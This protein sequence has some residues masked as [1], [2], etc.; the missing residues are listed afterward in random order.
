MDTSSLTQKI[1]SQARKLITDYGFNHF[2]RSY[3]QRC[4]TRVGGFKCQ[5]TCRGGEDFFL[6][7]CE[8]YSACVALLVDLWRFVA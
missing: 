1:V 5:I 8:T 2:D 4:Q 3:H 7:T 6:L